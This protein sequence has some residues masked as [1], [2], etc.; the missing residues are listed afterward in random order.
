MAA[1]LS[2]ILSA[3]TAAIFLTEERASG[4][5]FTA[6]CLKNQNDEFLCA[7]TAPDAEVDPAAGMTGPVG[8][9]YRT[10]RLY[11]KLCVR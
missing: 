3:L 5:L 4:R 9:V 2:F 11:H 7:T 1:G 10:C 8:C 6:E